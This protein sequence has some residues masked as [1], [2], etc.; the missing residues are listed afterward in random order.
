MLG[1]KF[2]IKLFL[3]FYLPPCQVRF[4]MVLY[5]H[6]QRPKGIKQKG[7]IEM[8]N[9][10]VVL[11][12]LSDS[13]NKYYSASKVYRC[14]VAAIDAKSTGATLCFLPMRKVAKDAGYRKY[15]VQVAQW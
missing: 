6:L 13:S 5:R 7:K 10:N 15:N 2:H 14:Q 3:I 12:Y 11:T 1:G 9:Y 4:D 8:K